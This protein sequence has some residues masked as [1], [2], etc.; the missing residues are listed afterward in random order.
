[1]Q[2][3]LNRD[4][5]LEENLALYSSM[6]LRGDDS[7]RFHS[8]VFVCL[9]QACASIGALHQGRQIH[10][11]IQGKG[12]ERDL[13]VGSTLV[14]M[15]VVCGTVDDAHTVFRRMPRKNLVTWNALLSG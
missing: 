10:A 9:L 12:M 14:Y 6:Q 5:A 3:L 11:H 8:V 1:M 7:R 2:D 13:V 15:Y 4:L